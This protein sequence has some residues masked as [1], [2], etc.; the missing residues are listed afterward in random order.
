MGQDEARALLPRGQGRGCWDYVLRRELADE[1][2]PVVWRSGENTSWAESKGVCN[3]CTWDEL[4]IFKESRRA[5]WQELGEAAVGGGGRDQIFVVKKA[6]EREI[7]I[8]KSVES[9]LLEI[10]DHGCSMILFVSWKGWQLLNG[11]QIRRLV[12]LETVRRWLQRLQ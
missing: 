5:R 4:G 3:P 1:E 8:P 7:F 12:C 9:Q 6:R 10:F 11:E 2:E